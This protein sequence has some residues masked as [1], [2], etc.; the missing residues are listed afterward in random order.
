MFFVV[1]L[2]LFILEKERACELWGSVGGAE[3]G[4]RENLKQ[5]PSSEQSP[6]QAPFQ[7]PEIMT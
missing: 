6:T 7:E 4:E 3:R 2:D 1:V 5:A